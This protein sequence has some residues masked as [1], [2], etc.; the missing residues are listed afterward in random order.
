MILQ[1]R[2]WRLLIR[3][4]VLVLASALMLAFA[5]PASYALQDDRPKQITRAAQLY[6]KEKPVE[7]A[8]V[9]TRALPDL[10]RVV[11]TH[12]INTT[13]HW[14]PLPGYGNLLFVRVEGDSFLHAYFRNMDLNLDTEVREA[15]FYGKVTSLKSQAGT[16]EVIK[17]L[18]G[19]GINVDKD[20]AMVL[21]QGEEPST[22]RPMVPVV[23]VLALFWI[24]ALVGL[25]QILSGRRNRHRRRT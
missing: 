13:Y 9:Y 22:Y 3:V 11:T 5:A 19:S 15:N 23:G 1:S 6:D 24:L 21:L 10:G 20:K 25:V 8:Y 17:A 4:V 7:D 12:T 2:K 16:E 18:A 14:I